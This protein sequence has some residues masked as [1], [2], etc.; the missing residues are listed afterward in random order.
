MLLVVAVCVLGTSFC[1]VDEL[2]VVR[3]LCRSFRK[4]SIPIT[5]NIVA[6]INF[7]FVDDEDFLRHGDVITTI[8]IPMSNT[9]IYLALDII[10][11]SG[12]SAESLR[13]FN[14]CWRKAGS[15][16][17]SSIYLSKISVK[18]EVTPGCK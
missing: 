15:G 17:F 6:T 5:T 7:R 1:V 8:I 16:T 3:T 13:L 9:M 11:A 4:R 14:E 12:S 18:Y 10:G 2:D